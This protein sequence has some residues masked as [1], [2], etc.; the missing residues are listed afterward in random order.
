MFVKI[1]KIIHY[2]RV[3]LQIRFHNWR[4]HRRMRTHRLETAH[5]GWMKLRTGVTG[6]DTALTDSTK[7]YDNVPSHRYD[8]PPGLNSIEVRALASVTGVGCT[9]KIYAARKLGDVALVCSLAV[10]TGTQETTIDGVTYYY[11]DTIVVTS[12][13][14]KDI[15]EAD[16]AG[17]DGMSRI[18]FDILGYDEVFALISGYASG[19]W[20]VDITG[21]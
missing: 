14:M 5:I 1:R 12:S 15:K 20:R 3:Q 16:I 19:T 13:W 21:F 10:T 7:E 18:G 9:I 8:V 4:C 17:N 2:R 11:V 6:N